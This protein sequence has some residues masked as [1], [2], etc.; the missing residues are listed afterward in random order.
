MKKRE[1]QSIYPCVFPIKVVGE[2]SAE[3]ETAVLSI[4]RGYVE[5]LSM[6]KIG[7]KTSAGGKYL[8]LTIYVN[9]ESREYLDA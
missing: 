9:A 4:M 5:E 7:R 8:S 3:F 2:C 6:E 1:S